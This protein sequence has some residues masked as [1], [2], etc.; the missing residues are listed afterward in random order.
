MTKYLD[1]QSFQVYQG[2]IVE[3]TEIL[4]EQ[5]DYIFFTGSATV[6]KII[7]QAAA[8]NLTPVTLELGNP[9]VYYILAEYYI[10]FLIFTLC[11]TCCNIYPESIVLKATERIVK[12]FYI[13]SK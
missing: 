3:T 8:R 11:K 4:N 7:H 1:T 10:Y 6:G 12:H 5:V 9:C 2:G 13:F